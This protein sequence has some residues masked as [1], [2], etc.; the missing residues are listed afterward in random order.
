MAGVILLKGHGVFTTDAVH[1]LYDDDMMRVL[2]PHEIVTRHGDNVNPFHINPHTNEKWDPEHFV[3]KDRFTAIVDEWTRKIGKRKAELNLPFDEERTK[4]AVREKVNISASKFNTFKDPNDPHQYPVIFPDIRTG[5]VNP[6]LLT[7]ARAPM[8]QKHSRTRVSMPDGSHDWDPKRD[9]KTGRL[10]EV[11]PKDMKIK[12]ANGEITHIVTSNVD[13]EDHGH[14]SEGE[15]FGAQ[16]ILDGEMKDAVQDANQKDLYLPGVNTRKLTPLKLSGG[17]VE[18]S[19]LVYRKMSNGDLKTAL[20]RHHANNPGSLGRQ[21]KTIMR[22]G[23]H[24]FMDA[25]F[26]LHP[27]FFEPLAI[28]QDRDGRKKKL[29]AAILGEGADEDAVNSLSKT[30]ALYLLARHFPFTDVNTGEETL[31]GSAFTGNPA[32]G[33]FTGSLGLLIHMKKALGVQHGETPFTDAVSEQR[34]HRYHHN[35]QNFGIGRDFANLRL[36]KHAPADMKEALTASLM[37]MQDSD[38]ARAA[39]MQ[40]KKLRGAVNF[41]RGEQ[42]KALLMKRFVDDGQSINPLNPNSFQWLEQE[43]LRRMKNQGKAP[44]NF[45][46]PWIDADY[47]GGTGQR[48]RAGGGDISLINP[49]R[50]DD[51]VQTSVDTLFDVMENLQSADAR[52]NNL[53][54]KSLP[55]RRRFNLSDSYDVL[56]LCE[57]F[58]LEKRDLHYIDQTMGDWGKIAQNL[59]VEPDVVKA[60][61]VAL[62]W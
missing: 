61:K 57:T 11:H 26:S 18:P 42:T 40:F 29:A 22:H 25:F 24:G 39:G 7:N 5:E 2:S 15:Y 8:Y 32:K 55:A 19:A 31:G 38:A 37:L 9:K 3:V 59:K 4:M 54:L 17:L 53:I 1:D 45:P 20:I 49:P 30:P 28:M 35:K 60:V 13:H 51:D 58:S 27:A 34:F 56:S 10:L 47:T 6:E 14:L 48:A 33:K 41:D 12:N 44:R 62:R 46:T 23:S 36:K 43:D 16:N 52:M 21:K 50:D